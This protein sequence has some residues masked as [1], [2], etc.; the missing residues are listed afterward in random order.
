MGWLVPVMF[1]AGLVL[2]SM[3]IESIFGQEFYT[4]NLWPKCLAGV[5]IAISVGILGYYL[6]VIK[7]QVMITPDTGVEVRQEA[8]TFFFIPFQY[9]GVIILVLMILVAI[10][11]DKKKVESQSYLS[12]PRVNDLYF[13][14]H[15]LIYNDVDPKFNY[16]AFKV[17][18]INSNGVEVYISQYSFSSKSAMRQEYEAGHFNKPDAFT[19][20]AEPISNETLNEYFTSGGLYQVVR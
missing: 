20:T 4:M 16:S 1:F 17:S 6:N 5:V 8:H 9:W 10:N 13:I 2:I 15:D 11:A 19:A 18:K 3:A 14:K 12:A 7:R